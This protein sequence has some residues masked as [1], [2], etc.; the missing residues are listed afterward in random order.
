MIFPLLSDQRP[1]DCSYNNKAVKPGNDYRKIR[2]NRALIVNLVN[3]DV[4]N[5]KVERGGEERVHKRQASHDHG[6]VDC[7]VTSEPVVVGFQYVKVVI[8]PNVKKGE[9]TA[10]N[11]SAPLSE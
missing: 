3:G 9:Q 10:V 8:S 5:K 4:K 6:K 11:P 1:P 7:D 2:A